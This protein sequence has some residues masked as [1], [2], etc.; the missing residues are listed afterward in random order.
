[1]TLLRA[2]LRAKSSSLRSVGCSVPESF[3]RRPQRKYS[4]GSDKYELRLHKQEPFGDAVGDIVLPTGTQTLEFLRFPASPRENMNLAV[5]EDV[6]SN[7]QTSTACLLWGATKAALVAS[8][9][10]PT[11]PPRLPA[12]KYVFNPNPVNG[13]AVAVAQADIKCGEIILVERP[14]IITPAELPLGVK[15]DPAETI[16]NMVLEI[17]TLFLTER[18][19]KGER[20]DFF[21]LS[22][23]EGR[24]IIQ[25]LSRNVISIAQ[26]LPGPYE[27]PHG[28]ICR[29]GSRMRHSCTPNV[30]VMWDSKSF[31]FEFFALT[32]IHKGDE[33]FRSYINHLL[34]RSE[35]LR[36]LDE[37]YGGLECSCPSCSLPNQQSQASDE[38]R[39][40]L[41]DVGTGIIQRSAL[42]HDDLDPE[43]T[44]WASDLNLPD[45]H[46]IEASQRILDLM[47][48]DGAEEI[49]LRIWHTT[50]MIRAYAALGDEE[51][52]KYWSARFLNIVHPMAVEMAESAVEILA[53]KVREDDDW[54][55]RNK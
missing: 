49:M 6:Q 7:M 46:L 4:S 43:F 40:F 51:K 12:N 20:E 45:D 26:P 14:L 34:P 30:E 18:L 25:T 36:L 3:L 13:T 39:E 33:L 53:G 31:T 17:F 21:G 11:S 44:A 23:T 54:D 38:I 32:P 9:F 52:A 19:S 47:T 2:S 35:R 16:A 28:G 42:G 5:E 24:S 50:R 37:E 10:Q 22:G 55:L 41:M 15:D 48:S 1:M 29:Q 27:G 8:G